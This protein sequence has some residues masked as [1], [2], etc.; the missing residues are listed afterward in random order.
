[1]MLVTAGKYKKANRKVQ[2]VNGYNKSIS[3]MYCNSQRQQIKKNNKYGNNMESL[4]YRWM[5]L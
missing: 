1:M 3:I 2:L 5:D 4:L